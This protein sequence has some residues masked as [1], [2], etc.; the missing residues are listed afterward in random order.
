M[1][2]VSQAI[3]VTSLYVCVLSP[4]QIHFFKSDTLYDV[5]KRIVKKHEDDIKGYLK[6]VHIQNKLHFSHKTMVN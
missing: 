6:L 4:F 5:N 1:K 2:Y 3:P